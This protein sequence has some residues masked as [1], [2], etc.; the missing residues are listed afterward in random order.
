M[1]IMEG[2]RRMQ[3]VMWV[4]IFVLSFSWAASSEE[5]QRQTDWPQFRGP[6]AIGVADGFKLPESWSAPEEKGILWKSDIPG[7]AHSSPIIWGDRIYLTTVVSKDRNPELK[8]G[9]YGSGDAAKDMEEQTWRLLCIDKKTGK[10]LWNKSVYQGVPSVARHTKASHCNST[11]ATNGKHLVAF[12]G[13]E[14]LFCFDMSGKLQWKK[15]LGRLAA[16]APEDAAMDWG[17]ASSPI[18]HDDRVFVQCDV[19][20]QAFVAAF[21]LQSGREI[22]RTNRKEVP[23]WG[24]PT[25]YRDGQ[26]TRIAVNGFKHI[27]GYDADNGKEIW[28]MVG[29]GDVPVPTPVV[30]DKLIYIAN[31]HGDIAPLYAVR[32]DAKGTLNAFDETMFKQLAWAEPKNGAYMQTPLVYRGCVY[33]CTDRGILKCYDAKW[34]ELHYQERLGKGSSGFT[35]SPVAGDGKVFVTNEDGDVHVVRA[36][37]KFELIGINQMGEVCMSTPAI[38]KSVLYIRTKSTLYAVGATD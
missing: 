13:A 3:R 10:V 37:A 19:H 11:P 22:W 21:D 31:A 5:V 24:T 9:I 18:I 7:L 29:G 30:C 14:G 35:A 15:D 32:T 4:V 20:D 38:S 8:V 6:E 28:K 12:L 36:G 27:G 33:S 34:G 25:I 16:G 23:T 17:F 26:A 1:L 2:K